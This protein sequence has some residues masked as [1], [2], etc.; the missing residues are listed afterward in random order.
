MYE[1]NSGCAI[2]SVVIVGIIC[3]EIGI[4]GWLLKWC[5]IIVAVI[6]AI[7]FVISLISDGISSLVDESK[8]KK[9]NKDVRDYGP[10]S[11]GNLIARG[12]REIVEGTANV[13]DL[14]RQTNEAEHDSQMARGHD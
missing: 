10:G 12:N 7:I 13:K 3:Y 11:I 9:M 4:L 5:L 14:T 1:E 8:I 2:V 6:A